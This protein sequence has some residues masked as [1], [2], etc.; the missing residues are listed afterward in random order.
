MKNKKRTGVFVCHCGINIAGTV[1]VK[2][3][4]ATLAKHE[5]VV[6]ATDYVYMCSDPGQKLI[7]ESIKEKNLD[8]VVVACCSPTLHESTFRK[9]T[10]MA[11]LNPYQC[12]IAN[13]REQCSWVHKDKEKAT[14]KAIKITKSIV[15]KVQRNIPLEPISVPLT[16][17]ALVI[18][19]GISGIQAALDIANGGYEVILV[20]RS[21]SIGGHMI[22]LSETFPTLDCSQCILTPKMVEVSKHP[23]I[24]LLT[25]SE[26]QE[27]SGFVGN[28]KVK[29]LKKPTY[30]DPDA[31]T[32]CGECA[33]VCPVVVPNEFDL[34]LT[35]RKAIY[36]PFPQAI[37]A[38]YTLDSEHCPGLVPIA[39]GKCIDVCEPKA[40]D[41]DMKPQIIEEEVGAIVVATG[42]DLYEKERM[43]EYGYGRIPDV[44]DGLQ[45]ERLL[46]ASGPTKGEV[47][48]PSDHRVPK[49]VV[50]IQ[51]CGSR[52]PELHNAYCSKICCM[53]TAKHAMLYKHHVP[54]GQAYVF[55]IDIRSG[56]KGYEEFVQR[57]TEE[58]GVVYLRGKVSKVFQQNGKVIVWG[59]D[60]LSGKDIQIEADMVVLAMAIRPSRG[61]TE[62]AKILKISVDKD[63]FFSE[64]HPKLRPVE[65]MVSG[66]FLAGM[67]QGPKDIPET[68]AQASGAASKVLAMFSADE[69]THD[70]IVAEVDENVCCGC[71]LCISQCPYDARIFDEE[72]G[73]VIV[74]EVLCEGCGACIAA[75][76]SGAAQQRNFTDEQILSMVDTI[77]EGEK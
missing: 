62:L 45:F 46:S 58:D 67:A 34:G 14:A 53:Y 76:P 1:D 6:L 65:S 57:A 69:L 75:C 55:Y 59:V 73:I 47:L 40:I 49:E 42:Y 50:F 22:Q 7:I 32:L 9:A 33:E 13:I 35:G 74:N 3:V 29:I 4:A 23:N 17:R 41:Y 18:G 37:P 72:K 44:L 56:G 27:I 66:M 20:E 8:S 63:G 43:A 64:A 54:D 24:K 28:F 48:R 2:K 11:G 39:C 77:L 30:V 25:Y 19:G 61:A 15:E 71:K 16:K 21:P 5:G 36:I 70:P 10:N 12:E 31:C 38:A 26:V 52:D 60:T 51:C 68:V